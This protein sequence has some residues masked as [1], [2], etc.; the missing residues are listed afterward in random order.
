M[1]EQRHKTFKGKF[2]TLTDLATFSGCIQAFY[3]GGVYRLLTKGVYSGFLQKGCIQDF[4]V[5]YLRFFNGALNPFL[6]M[7]IHKNGAINKLFRVVSEETF[8][9]VVEES[10][11]G[12][13]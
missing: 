2:L 10:I 13:K 12:V 3:K 6:W 9:G 4:H 11:F 5:V 7:Y 8:I 1:I